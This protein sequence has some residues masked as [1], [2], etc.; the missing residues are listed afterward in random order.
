MNG[1]EKVTDPCKSSRQSIIV[2]HANRIVVKKM[3][4]KYCDSRITHK[5]ENTLN[6]P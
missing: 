2:Y 3:C 4:E 5:V 1:K 6:L